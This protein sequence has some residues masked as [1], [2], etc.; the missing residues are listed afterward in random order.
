MHSEILVIIL[1]MAAVT[2]LTRFGSLLLFRQIGMPPWM[3]NW[4]KHVP[5]AVLT[6]LILPS[7]LLPK[8]Y[9]DISLNN[10]YL[11]AGIIASIVA[12]KSRNIMATVG[13]GI[14]CMYSLHWLDKM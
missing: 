12:Y 9:L 3:M 5:T 7:L 6:A 4:L 11:L 10:H 8:G 1:G 13:F 2:F 14:V